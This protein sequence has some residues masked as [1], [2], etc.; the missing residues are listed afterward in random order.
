MV[1]SRLLLEWL[2]KEIKMKAKFSLLLLFFNL[3]LIVFSFQSDVTASTSRGP[4][5]NWEDK[6]SDTSHLSNQF[7]TQVASGVL[8]LDFPASTTTYVNSQD[9][10]E[11]PNYVGN[12]CVDYWDVPSWG[13]GG[14]AYVTLNAQTSAQSTNSGRYYP[15]LA[16]RG[17]YQIAAWVPNH[18]TYVFPCTGYAPD[19][20]TEN[21]VYE[22]HHR[23]GTS[24]E[25]GSQAPLFNEWLSLNT[26]EFDAGSGYVKLTDLT[27]EA[28]GSHYVVF[29]DLRF[30]LSEMDGTALS[31][32]ITIPDSNTWDQ[33]N[34]S[35]TNPGG[36]SM[37][38]D[39][40]AADGT[41]VLLSNV[42]NGASLASISAETHPTIQLRAR[43]NSTAP[44]TSV[45]LDQWS[46]S[47]EPVGYTISG[48]IVDTLGSP[49]EA[50][51][52][53]TNTGLTTTTDS[54][55]DYLFVGL[56]TDTYTITPTKSAYTFT[57][58]MRMV[59]VPPNATSENFTGTT[60]YS[61]TGQ[62]TDGSGQ[63][64]PDI[65]VVDDTGNSALTDED[66]YYTLRDLAP[67]MH[68]LTPTVAVTREC[69]YSFVY[70]P[71]SRVA[72]VTSHMTAMN[73]G[74][75]AGILHGRVTNK[76]TGAGV[77]EAK[78]ELVYTSPSCWPR[79][80]LV[81][82]GFSVL[83]AEE[84]YSA[85]TVTDAD[86]NYEFTEL[87]ICPY[88]PKLHH[89]RSIPVRI[90]ITREYYAD[91]E[92]AL[93]I[94]ELDTTQNFSL[95]PKP[96][97]VPFFSQEDDSWD[98]H[99]LRG[100]D[101]VSD[102]IYT[103]GYSSIRDCG[104]TL[105]SASMLFTYYGAT[106]RTPPELS[107]CMGY[108][109][110]GFDWQIGANCSQGQARSYQ[111]FGF[112]WSRL[113]HELNVNKRP[114]MLKMVKGRSQHWVLVLSGSGTS[115]SN[116]TIHDPGYLAGSYDNLGTYYRSWYL[117]GLVVYDGQPG[118]WSTTGNQNAAEVPVD[119]TSFDQAEYAAGCSSIPAAG[120][121]RG[122][123]SAPTLVASDIITGDIYL[124]SREESTLTVK[125]E[126]HSSEERGTEMLLW[127]DT[128]SNTIWS[129]YVS[130]VSLP[131]SD[132]VYVQ[133]RDQSGNMSDVYSATLPGVA[134]GPPP[135]VFT[136]FLPLVLKQ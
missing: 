13:R 54:E 25:T 3:L 5:N 98:H 4:L 12:P 95:E 33:V 34:F 101:S 57:P 11:T 123:K 133:Y 43:F 106:D 89:F 46:V 1:N 125:L 26:Y 91:I 119:Q 81:S 118:C 104:C 36:T 44:P 40:L 114:V 93:D 27:G 121:D 112:S 9:M 55:G 17:R 135:S 129:P 100:C 128:I 122:F 124:Y 7:Q 83:P 28:L 29:D 64:V 35:R 71:T 65:V 49:V 47:W 117:N 10:V 14:H 96:C 22:I 82:T 19:W 84:G 42:A 56:I 78:V 31:E 53:T 87:P 107:D 24:T 30:V 92:T 67:G 85:A 75:K 72:N 80:W 69:M 105:T 23:N 126:A 73:F 41:T 134:G 32:L 58:T 102:C 63:P 18:T 76:E 130:Y 37:E 88:K 127:T 50:V 20:D 94:T 113:S 52:L 108:S 6:F 15:N 103:Y 62:I 59:S 110:C 48:T 8:Q 74:V 45:T 38:I 21:A 66:G 120:L 60:T 61:V 115:L 51:T 39:V 79:L 132:I 109:S 16:R 2:Q 68:I 111:Y 136:V 70:T 131:T 86:G 99:R 90:N 116:Y 77:S 97:P